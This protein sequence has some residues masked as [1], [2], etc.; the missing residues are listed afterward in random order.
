[1]LAG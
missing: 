1:M